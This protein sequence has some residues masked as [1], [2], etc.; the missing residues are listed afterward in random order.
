M[1]IS[2]RALIVCAVIAAAA[3]AYER[4]TEQ[5]TAFVYPVRAERTVSKTLGPFNTLFECRD[6][7]TAELAR[8]GVSPTA[9]TYA[10]GLN[11]DGG[12]KLGDVQICRKM[13]D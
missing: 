1:K 4:L 8:M 5:W 10:C 13:S 7:A 3:F 9:G 11:C 6:Q 2:S 12:A